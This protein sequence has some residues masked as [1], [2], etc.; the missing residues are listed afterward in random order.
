MTNPPYSEELA[1]GFS[2]DPLGDNP[3]DHIY[4][5]DWELGGLDGIDPR[6]D[7]RWM[8]TTYTYYD[9]DTTTNWVTQ[10][11]FCDDEA[12]N[13]FTF[14]AGIVGSNPR[15]VAATRPG[16]F[17]EMLPYLYDKATD[18]VSPNKEAISA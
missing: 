15:W 8:P 4:P 9:A 14:I 3:H 7:P 6:V 10:V 18:T 5:D 12:L 2:H 13:Y 11:P 1:H 17:V 16:N